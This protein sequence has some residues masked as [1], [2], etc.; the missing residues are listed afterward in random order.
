MAEIARFLPIFLPGEAIVFQ[1]PNCVDLFSPSFENK[2]CS[3]I[4]TN[5][6]LIPAGSDRF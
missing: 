5:Y 4:V 6:R 1:Y 2:K 3:L